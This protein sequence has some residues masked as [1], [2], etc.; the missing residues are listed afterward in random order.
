[1]A[2]LLHAELDLTLFL[3]QPVPL[4]QRLGHGRVALARFLERTIG[5]GNAGSILQKGFADLD[6][7]L[8]FVG[9]GGAT[10]LKLQAILLV[11]IACCNAV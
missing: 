3:L 10:L 7:L 11:V 5:C 2:L 8:G 9:V 4:L 6:F 1:M